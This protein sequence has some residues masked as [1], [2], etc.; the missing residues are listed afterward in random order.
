MCGPVGR[1]TMR[2]DAVA[3]LT[4]RVT[5]MARPVGASIPEL[6]KERFQEWNGSKPLPAWVLFV[7]LV[8]MQR[9]ATMYEQYRDASREMEGHVKWSTAAGTFKNYLA[10]LGVADMVDLGHTNRGRKVGVAGNPG[11][12]A[13]LRDHALK[14]L[15]AV[16]P[17][18]KIV[19]L[20]RSPSG[21]L[22]GTQGIDLSNLV[23]MHAALLAEAGRV[24]RAWLGT[25]TDDWQNAWLE[26]LPRPVEGPPKPMQ[27]FPAR[28]SRDE[29]EMEDPR[30]LDWD[31]LFRE[32]RDALLGATQTAQALT[33]S[34]FASRFDCDVVRRF[35]K[36]EYGR[37]IAI[38]RRQR[39][40]R[41]L[42]EERDWLLPPVVP[43]EYEIV[44]P[45]RRVMVK[46]PRLV[47]KLQGN[48]EP[49]MVM[50][51]EMGTLPAVRE[52]VYDW[53]R[54][55]IERCEG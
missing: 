35:A 45:A 49:Q 39:V 36:S 30:P 46:P 9:L 29:A 22:P 47:L 7:A 21:Y 3:S 37:S 54:H 28:D 38:A 55:F 12:I 48:L 26:G 50:E 42:C 32:L 4:A 5:R 10:S 11:A 13:K 53:Y 16:D 51:P 14:A 20:L 44:E 43:G 27:R 1:E 8:P 31:T 25:Q 33:L 15:E 18:G 34:A 52:P 19:A 23:T 17:T 41:S 2:D 6:L 40:W 24:F